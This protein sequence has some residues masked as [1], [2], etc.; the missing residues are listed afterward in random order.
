MRNENA[1]A[2]RVS[3]AIALLDR[4][5]GNVP[6]PIAS[7]EATP[8]Q[9]LRIEHHCRAQSLPTRSRLRAGPSLPPL[10]MFFVGCRAP[11]AILLNYHIFDLNARIV[12]RRYDSPKW[13]LTPFGSNAPYALRRP[14]PEPRFRC[15]ASLRASGSVHLSP[16]GRRSRTGAVPSGV[17]RKAK[18]QLR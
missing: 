3:A 4:G 7:G 14:G 15:F 12:I 8:Q 5:W 13:R 18:A 10:E 16:R 9:R 1:N 2:A 17:V 6:Q 11:G